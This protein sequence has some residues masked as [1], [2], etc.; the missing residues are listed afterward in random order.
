VIGNRIDVSRNAAADAIRSGGS[1]GS[2]ILGLAAAL[3]ILS[4]AA[5]CQSTRYRASTLPVELSARSMSARTPIDLASLSHG[6]S[7]SDRVYPGDTLA[8]TLATGIEDR[9]PTPWRVRVTPQ[10]VAN[11]PE[12]GPIPLAGMRLADAERAIY[13]VS[14]QRKLYRNPVVT[15]TLD[16]RQT[17]HITVSG[18]VRKPASFDIPAPACDLST[19]LVQA[20]GL[21]D[22]HGGVVVIKNRVPPLRR[23]WPPLRR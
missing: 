11:V 23:S 21:A 2:L 17:H 16:Q 9:P 10:G 18:A 15:V 12:L 6:A 22:D 5:G 7:F 8:I 13:D 3:A 14:I 19:A 4:V 1:R 20:G